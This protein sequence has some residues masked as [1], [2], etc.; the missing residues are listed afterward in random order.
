M[1]MWKGEEVLGEESFFEEVTSELNI[2]QNSLFFF[3]TK[4]KLVL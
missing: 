1:T 2:E 3:Q 4:R